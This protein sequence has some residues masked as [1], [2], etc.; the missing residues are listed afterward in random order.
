MANL[1]Y[2]SGNEN[3]VLGILKMYSRMG[4]YP[5]DATSVFNSKADLEA[6]IAERVKF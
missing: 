2:T 3:K 4:A 5:L 1:P 6:Y